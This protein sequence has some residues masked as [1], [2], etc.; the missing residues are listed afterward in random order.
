[1]KEI[2]KLKTVACFCYNEFDYKNAIEQFKEEELKEYIDESYVRLSQQVQL[3]CMNCEQ[4]MQKDMNTKN[5]YTTYISVELQDEKSKVTANH[6]LCKKCYKSLK[7]NGAT[8]I[9][10]N[11]CETNHSVAPVLWK[12][13]IIE[14]KCHCDCTIF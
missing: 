14:K 6:L 4:N 12:K 2:V 1:M 10:C 9:K 5:T 3:F 11:L 7:G 8:K 13:K